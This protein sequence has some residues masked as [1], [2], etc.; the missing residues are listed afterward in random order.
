[1][2]KHVCTLPNELATK[3]SKYLLIHK[4]I[5]TYVFND[6]ALNKHFIKT[7]NRVHSSIN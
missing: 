1:M 7:I 4:G 3:L 2:L 6:N 5:I